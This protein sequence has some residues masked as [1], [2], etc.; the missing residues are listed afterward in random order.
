MFNPRFVYLAHT[1][2]VYLSSQ[3]NRLR[4]P[5]HQAQWQKQELYSHT[6]DSESEVSQLEQGVKRQHGHVSPWHTKSFKYA[7]FGNFEVTKPRQSPH[8]AGKTAREILPPSTRNKTAMQRKTCDHQAA[9]DVLLVEQ[10]QNPIMASKIPVG[11]ELVEDDAKD[12]DTGDDPHAEIVSLILQTAMIGLEYRIS[13]VLL[14]EALEKSAEDQPTYFS[15]DMFRNSKGERLPIHYCKSYQASERVAA[16]F[17]EEEVIGFDLEWNSRVS[18]KNTNIKN[19]VSV[20]QIAS[21]TRI[22]IFQLALHKGDTPEQI[23]PPSLRQ[24]MEDEN[25]V[26]LG[27]GILND[28]A[29]VRRHLKVDGKGIIELSHLHNLVTDRYKNSV[30]RKIESVEIA[31]GSV[32]LASQTL[33][34]LYLALGKGDVRTSKWHLELNHEQCTYAANDVWVVIC[35]YH[36]LERKRLEMDPVP[37]RPHFAEKYL[38]IIGARKTQSELDKDMDS[39]ESNDEASEHVDTGAGATIQE[40]D[41]DW[42]S[43]DKG[44][45]SKVESVIL[46]A[47]E[48]SAC[49]PPS[50][51]PVPGHHMPVKSEETSPKS[52]IPMPLP[53]SLSSLTAATVWVTNYAATVHPQRALRVANHKLHAYTYWHHQG[54]TL[55]AV[56]ASLGRTNTPALVATYILDSIELERLPHDAERIQELL[57]H[58]PIGKRKKHE[59]VL[60]TIRNSKRQK[61][62]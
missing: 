40:S 44:L 35:L 3:Y 62:R 13:E 61:V 33:T 31:K 22:A 30:D 19:H 55:S 7:N 23:L 50:S 57:D 28:F 21:S 5:S 37:E 10:A 26:K 6:T 24:I 46:D 36:E 15:C 60:A 58:A 47:P 42:L 4:L 1:P 27:V 14:R 9:P 49:T 43:I 20:I 52:S 32:A 29:R 45:S 34:H 39:S 25:I 48:S 51:T 2:R 18:A 8:D 53:S 16:M 12:K 38:P 41:D 17:L 56:A 11:P 54:A 59:E